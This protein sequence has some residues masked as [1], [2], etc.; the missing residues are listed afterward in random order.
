[1]AKLIKPRRRSRRKKVGVAVLKS[2]YNE[3]ILFSTVDELQ[4]GKIKLERMRYV[5]DVVPGL[6]FVMNRTGLVTFHIQ[7]EV[8]KER[9]YLLL[10]SLNKERD[11]HMSIQE[12]RDVAETVKALAEKGTDP[13]E[14][15]H[16]RLIRELKRDGAN[17]KSR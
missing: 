16:R 7:Y 6:R 8:G 15:L 5:D 2:Q 14:G 10:G 13:A 1:L 17:W 3:K 4:S 9:K 11:D 12:A